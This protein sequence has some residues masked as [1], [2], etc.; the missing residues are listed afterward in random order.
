MQVYLN[1]KRRSTEGWSIV[2]VLLDW[3]GGVLSVAQIVMQCAVLD[4]W[5]QIAGNPVKFG[6]G[7]VSLSFDIVF[8]VQHYV[9]YASDGDPSVTL[10][11][12]DVINL[13]NDDC[14]DSINQ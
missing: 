10:R 13:L 5:R 11:A 8:M 9:L 6:L 14:T 1:I 7:F 3:L 2:N 4:D 12:P